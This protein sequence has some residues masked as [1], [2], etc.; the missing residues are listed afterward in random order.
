MWDYLLNVL[1][2]G[3]FGLITGFYF[4]MWLAQPYLDRLERK[5]EKYEQERIDD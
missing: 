4:A 3:G 2:G 5:V 1:I